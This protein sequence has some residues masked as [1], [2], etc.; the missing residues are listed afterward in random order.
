MERVI[1][2]WQVVVVSYVRYFLAAGLVYLIF[3]KW[4]RNSLL[5]FKIQRAFP[6]VHQVQKEIIM[7]LTTLLLFAGFI[8]VLLFTPLRQHTKLYNHWS[9]YPWIFNLMSLPVIVFLHDTYFYWI[10]RFMHLPHVYQRVHRVHH[11]SRNPT[12]FAAFSFHPWEAILEFA[13]LPLLVF[14]FPVHRV[15]LAIFGAYMLFTNVCG[16]LGFELVPKRLIGS[17]WLRWLN[18]STSHNMHHQF[19]HGNYGLYFNLWD[20]WMGTN[21]PRYNE[22]FLNVNEGPSPK[23]AP[24]E[25]RSLDVVGGKIPVDR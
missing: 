24:H 4:G 17:R 8:Y 25:N 3:Y 15:V 20:Q 5:R 2:L 10:H 21:H 14:L 23:V 6:R 1:E 7:S 11:E 16:H 9:D 22:M 13:F 18:T 19:S 12:P